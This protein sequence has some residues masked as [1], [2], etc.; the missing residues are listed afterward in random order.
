M[1]RY[2]EHGGFVDLPY[3]DAYGWDV[4]PDWRFTRPS[5]DITPLNY[6]ATWTDVIGGNSAELVKL[7]LEHGADPR[8]DDGLEQW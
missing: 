2:L 8:R 3:K 6:V 5:E 7:L 4:G 1:R